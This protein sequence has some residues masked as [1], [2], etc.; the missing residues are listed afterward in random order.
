MKTI[1]V[2][3]RFAWEEWGGT[4]TVVFETTR[5][6]AMRGQE[7]SIVTLNALSSSKRENTEGVWVDRFS[8]FYP[9]LGLSK[10]ARRRMDKK[11]GNAF[12]LSLARHLLKQKGVD[13]IHLHT[14]KRIGGIARTVARM[15]RIPYVITIHGGCLDV[16]DSE[17]ASWTEPADG[18]FEWGKALGWLVGSR[19]VLRDANAIFSVGREEA[20]RLREEFP[21]KRII[22]IPNGVDG[23]RFA[24][25][26]GPRFRSQYGIDADA[27]VI[28]TVARIDQQKNQMGLLRAFRS[29]KETRP[30]VRLVLIGAVT[31]PTYHASL[32]DFVAGAG[33]ADSVTV[34]PGLGAH[35]EGLV[36]AYHAANVFALPS[37]HEPFGLVILEAWCAGLPV[38]ASRVG[39]IRSLVQEGED[40][41]LV[42]ATDQRQWVES[43]EW[44][45]AHPAAARGLAANGRSK[46]RREFDWGVVV[47]RMLKVYR[48]VIDEYP[49]H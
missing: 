37:V 27:K 17:R 31:D 38:V 29:L 12:S 35:S 5:Q 49:V 22:Q 18:S 30:E 48:E 2:P 32:K 28:L 11:G 44:V 13:L 25:G 45:L 34:I 20:R 46:A 47:D 40:A 33:L 7:A 16:P 9:Y 26:N 4:E 41:L 14:G 42:D 21:Y 23:N 8:Y 10:S 6:L 3:R 1:H 19:R 39:G 43:L 24:T 15:K 36:D